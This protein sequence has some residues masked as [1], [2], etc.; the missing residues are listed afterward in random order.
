MNKIFISLSLVFLVS[1][2]S[3]FAQAQVSSQEEVEQ[4]AKQMFVDAIDRNYESIVNMSHP[5]IFE[6][7]SKEVL[8]EQI[9]G[10]FEGNEEVKITMPD[11]IPLYKVSKVKEGS[12]S[13]TKYAFVSYDMSMNMTFLKESFDDEMKGT[14]KNMMSVQGLDVTFISDNSVD[15][16]IKDTLTLLVKDI[17]TNDQW[18]MIN[19]DPD[20]PLFYN[21]L[22]SDVIEEARK[23]KQDL[24][25]EKSKN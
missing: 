12:N 8:L 7:V 23:Y 10:M 9:K 11:T 6:M 19:Y 4:L 16:L 17:D 13:G 1:L 25:L 18:V 24:M 5:K 15:V 14:M 21:I 22:S 20:S 3:N 2:F